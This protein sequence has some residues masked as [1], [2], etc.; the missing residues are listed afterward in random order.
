MGLSTHVLDAARGGAAVGVPVHWESRRDDGTWSFTAA[1]TTDANGR[2][3]A[4][5]WLLSGAVTETAPPA[6]AAGQ[7][8]L[9]FD[10]G[11]W[12]LV[13]GLPGFFPE[14]AVAFTVT[15]PECHHHVPLLL[16]P[17]AYS[18]YRGT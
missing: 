9:V 1:G 15:T 14:V 10:T 2:I 7:H 3:G 18:T 11:T 13:E 8:R 12:F 6:L 16:S 5:D 17:Y 4:A